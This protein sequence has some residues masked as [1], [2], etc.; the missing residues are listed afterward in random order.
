MCPGRLQLV[1]FFSSYQEHPYLLPVIYS[2]NSYIYHALLIFV[3]DFALI[4]LFALLSLF[5][6]L[7][8]LLPVRNPC[9]L[10]CPDVTFCTL[11]PIYV[12]MVIGGGEGAG[13]QRVLPLL[14]IMSEV[15]SCAAGGGF[16]VGGWGGWVVGGQKAHLL[17]YFRN[18][19]GNGPG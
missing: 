5:M 16:L 4:C 2:C 6:H 3:P 17:S 18:R 8:L 10:C 11:C 7:E 14:F 1:R 12:H 15:N 9:I 13:L 19:R